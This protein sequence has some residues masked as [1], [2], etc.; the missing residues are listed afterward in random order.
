DKYMG[1]QIVRTALRMLI[2]TGVRPGELR[3]AEW[4]EI[5]LD[6][7]VWTIPAEKMKMRRTHVVPLSEQVIDLLKQIQPIS[8]SYQYVFPSRTDYR[9]HISDMAINTMIRRMGYSG[10][11]TGHGFR[12]TMSTILHDQDFD[13]AW[14]EKQLAHV[15][16]NS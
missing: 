11:A 9:K 13:T 6:K 2:L 7:A 15:D 1:S 12:H 5:D 3:K 4:S 14:V 10:R 16:K 8:G